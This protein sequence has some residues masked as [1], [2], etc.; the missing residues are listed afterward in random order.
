[1]NKKLKSA[2]CGA[3]VFVAGS[4]GLSACSVNIDMKSNIDE[5]TKQEE[6]IEQGEQQNET[7]TIIN[8]SSA[9]AKSTILQALAKSDVND[10]RNL[11]EKWGSFIINYEG[12]ASDRDNAIYTGNEKVQYKNGE[13]VKYSQTCEGAWEGV[14]NELYYDG[15]A[16]Y[17][18]NDD[19][20]KVEIET[21]ENPQGTISTFFDQFF[22][23]KLFSNANFDLYNEQVEKKLIENNKYSLTLKISMMNFCA[24]MGS[25]YPDM[26][27]VP[28]T[29]REKQGCTLTLTFT[30]DQ[31]STAKFEFKFGTTHEN[32]D[33]YLKTESVEYVKA[34]NLTITAPTWYNVY[35]ANN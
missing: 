9:E 5:P 20:K 32:G 22:E 6:Q 19:K 12:L 13:R 23:N 26:S 31:I 28:A 35:K 33:F 24:M 15:E 16:R 30:N 34:S 18:Y 10:N 4:V 29:I 17:V 21:D 2:L 27:M 1:M 7:V 25:S 8:I 3:L 14:S 11:L